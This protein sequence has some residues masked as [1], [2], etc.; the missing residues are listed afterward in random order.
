MTFP[1]DQERF[2]VDDPELLDRLEAEAKLVM[3]SDAYE[4]L[5]DVMQSEVM[6]GGGTG[7][8]PPGYDPATD[9]LRKRERET[10]RKVILGTVATLGAAG[11]IGGIVAHNRKRDHNTD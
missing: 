1:A 2:K 5:V 9:S 8:I 11:I 4:N 7:D 3:G 10:A 6:F